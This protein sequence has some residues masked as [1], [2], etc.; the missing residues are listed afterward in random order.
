MDWALQFIEDNKFKIAGYEQSLEPYKYNMANYLFY[1]RHYDRCLEYLQEGH[2]ED[3][4]YKV[5]ARILELKVYYETIPEV[6]SSKLNAAKMFFHRDELLP[7]EK[8][9]LFNAFVDVLKQMVASN[10][11]GN[12]KRVQSIL[13][14][15]KE[16]PFIAERYWLIEKLEEMLKKAGKKRHLI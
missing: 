12:E 16:A 5:W 6:V 8:R 14:K 9:I 3:L 13:Q 7:D 15:V 2:Y 11:L 4:H 1:S 10:T